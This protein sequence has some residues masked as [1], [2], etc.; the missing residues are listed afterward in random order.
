M[1]R[2][3]LVLCGILA[4]GYLAWMVLS[5]PRRDGGAA[6]SAFARAL[7]YYLNETNQD[8]RRARQELL[9]LGDALADNAAYH[10]DL[11]L[12]DL[13][14][15]N[16][17]VQDED[18][19]VPEEP[20]HRRLLLSAQDRLE[21]A[22][23]IAPRMEAAEYN[24]ARVYLKLAPESDD[25]DALREAAEA[26]L[27][28]LTRR[29]PPDPAALLL[30]GQCREDA[31]D[32]AGAFD[33]YS[34]VVALGPDYV[35]R[36]LYRVASFRR[37]QALLRLPGREEE[38]RREIEE[39]KRNNPDNPRPAAGALESGRY[40]RLA[41]P[42]G[43]PAARPDP[44]RMNWRNVT[45]RA[46]VPHARQWFLA[47]DLD[48]DC[49]RDLVLRGASGLHV[50]RNRRNASFEDLTASSGL[51]A[52]FAPSGGA[53]GDLDND[54]RM[55]LV[56]AGTAGIRV[57]LNR[58]PEDERTKWRFAEAA[59]EEGKNPIGDRAAEPALCVALWDLDH[60]GDLD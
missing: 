59:G 48:D 1:R 12:I 37:A 28:P 49:A 13:S 36:T 57:F 9:P 16:H 41:D 45:A 56:L 35:A 31:E 21:R 23:A 52:D 30:H 29:E 15:L 46:G 39:W 24:L 18:R 22:L 60:D 47:P 8:C 11:A 58:T 6:R 51:P 50:L 53:A 26:L 5:E 27:E 55:D 43:A 38:G 40:T 14:E 33:S 25:P 7:A 34:R 32:P 17:P 20:R 54:G 19:L 10:L 2:A 3:L 42:A 4:G 44:R